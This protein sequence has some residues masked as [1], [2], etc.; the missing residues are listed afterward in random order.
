MQSQVKM[1]KKPRRWLRRLKIIAIT[2]VVLLLILMY[3][4]IPFLFSRLITSASTRPM[5]RR[6]TET[7][8]DLGAQFS[9]VQFQASDGVTISAWFMPS[10][11]KGITIIYSHGL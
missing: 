11:G 9:N 3:G 6:L 1:Q 7:P 2:L 4:V 10:H 8:S 5:D